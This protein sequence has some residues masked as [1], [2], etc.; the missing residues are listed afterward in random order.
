M[1]LVDNVGGPQLNWAGSVETDSGGGWLSISPSAATAP[2]NVTVTANPAGQ[3]LGAYHGR[4]LLGAG[5]QKVTVPVVMVVTEDGPAVETDFSAAYWEAAEGRSAVAPADFRSLSAGGG[6]VTWSAQATELTGSGSWASVMPSAGVSTP[7]SAS[8][9]AL[10]ASTSGLAPGLYGTLVK[11]AAAGGQSQRWVT[12]MLRV[13]PAASTVPITMKP[14]GAI[15]ESQ[16]GA[17]V[18]PKTVQVWRNREGQVGFQTGASTFDGMDWLTVTPARGETGQLGSTNLLLAAD[19]TGLEPGIYHGLASITFG[20]GVVDSVNVTFA[21]K[22]AFVCETTSISIAPLSPRFG[23]SGRIGRAVRLEAAVLDN[24]G[25]PVNDAAMIAVFTSGDTALPLRPVSEGRYAATWSPVAANSQVNLFFQAQRGPMSD[26]TTVI[27]VVDGG[28][29]TSISRFG[30]V[31]AA[32]FRAGEAI[33]PGE[34]ISVFGRNLT[35]GRQFTADSIPLPTQLGDTSLRVGA[36]QAP[37]Y[38]ASRTQLNLQ[39]PF[40]LDPGTTTQLVALSGSDYSVPEEVA[41]ASARPGVFAMIP[42]DPG[43]AIVQNQDTSLNGPANPAARGSAIVA[44]V[45]GVGVVEPAVSTGAASPGAEPLA[46]AK[47]SAVATL[48]GFEAEVL[49]LGMTPDFVGLAQL[50]LIVPPTAPIG[51]NVPLIL[52]VDGQPSNTL[53]VAIKAAP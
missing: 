16:G 43:R 49:Y 7:A 41:V 48:G 52:K 22:P 8:Q 14:A 33:A 38:F 40:E 26:A 27:G 11:V 46:R 17:A 32:S 42:N 36:A 9:F 39:A 1:L 45:S 19:P 53:S 15:L 29:A 35:D 12:G 18:T 34:I 3:Q 23:F 5:A 51:S 20:D 13:T 31:D 2:T 25:R 47:G 10:S 28:S 6:S 44:Y 21:V 50:N 37:F 30:V 4:V 24:C